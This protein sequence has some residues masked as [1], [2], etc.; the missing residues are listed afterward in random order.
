QGRREV[1]T[2]VG[3]LAEHYRP[4]G[5]E[6]PIRFE[7]AMNPDP[8]RFRRTYRVVSSALEATDVELLGARAGAASFSEATRRHYL[9]HPDDPRYAQL[10]RKILAEMLPE[11]LRGEPVAQ[12]RAITAWL[13]RE[14]TYTL[15]VPPAT[16]REDPTAAFLFGDLMGY[17][18]HFS[19]AAALLFRSI[20]L[21]ARV[22]TGYAIPEQ[23]RRGG[24]AL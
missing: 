6:S 7:D 21:P 10:A 5:L 13:E 17:C 9:E 18:V 2:S 3:L 8:R 11:D 24:S 16:S 4:F 1:L 12:V 22:A 23:A 19:H 20:G 14:G 15:S